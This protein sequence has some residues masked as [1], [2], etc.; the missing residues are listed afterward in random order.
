MNPEMMC[1]KSVKNIP[2]APTNSGII[3]PGYI[4]AMPEAITSGTNQYIITT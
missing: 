2:L 3:I 1:A 4:M